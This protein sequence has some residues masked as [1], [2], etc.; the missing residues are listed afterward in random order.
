MFDSF[1]RTEFVYP[2]QSTLETLNDK[3]YRNSIA[4]DLPTTGK[5]QRVGFI[6]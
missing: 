3:G 5:R 6:L 4:K 1:L 2:F